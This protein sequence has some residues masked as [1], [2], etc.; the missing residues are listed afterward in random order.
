MSAIWRSQEK[1]VRIV[2]LSA[3]TQCCL[4]ALRGPSV[5]RSYTARRLRRCVLRREPIRASGSFDTREAIFAFARE[6]A[7]A[8]SIGP[9]CVEGPLQ[10]GTQHGIGDRHGA[11]HGISRLASSSA[12]GLAV[13]GHAAAQQLPVGVLTAA[14]PK[15][16]LA[17]ASM[18]PPTSAVAVAVGTNAA[19]TEAGQATPAS[20]P[21]G[22]KGQSSCEVAP[23]IDVA[24]ADRPALIASLSA[25]PLL[26]PY[27]GDQAAQRAVNEPGSK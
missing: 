24:S 13:C 19:T 18:G 27:G 6:C 2:N 5:S 23:V 4:L 3:P 12:S 10:G 22:V 17:E 14:P 26:I 16:A 9:A 15:S 1:H 21:P 20:S 7:G 11:A 8:C 25:Q